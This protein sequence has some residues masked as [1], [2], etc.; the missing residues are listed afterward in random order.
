[1]EI[2]IFG[3]KNFGSLRVALN[4][5]GETLFCLVDVCKA[6]G[7]GNP[8]DVKKRLDST[9]LDSIEVCTILVVTSFQ[10]RLSPAISDV[11]SRQPRRGG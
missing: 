9:N 5:K 7:I 1:M 10:M 8:S 6:L 11:A 2:Q 3:S 4:E